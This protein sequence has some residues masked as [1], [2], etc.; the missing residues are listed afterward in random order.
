[1]K[2][3]HEIKM[4]KLMFGLKTNVCWDQLWFG[5]LK[6]AVWDSII[7]ILR[8]YESGFGFVGKFVD[9]KST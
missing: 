7:L 9:K 6:M 4:K 1:M 3:L 5:K 2:H 8:K